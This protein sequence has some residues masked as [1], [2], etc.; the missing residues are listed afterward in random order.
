MGQCITI[1]SDASAIVVLK[2]LHGNTPYK[3]K[4]N[5]IEDVVSLY[6]MVQ[7]A[8]ETHQDAA[9]NLCAS[10][11]IIRDCKTSSIETVRSTDRLQEQCNMKTSSSLTT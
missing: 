1:S 2:M 7:R 8:R 3:T 4:N 11:K 10:N 5:L 6:E 9:G